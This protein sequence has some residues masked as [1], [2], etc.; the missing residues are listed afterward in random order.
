M[1]ENT[2]PHRPNGLGHNFSKISAMN[3]T[4]EM[5]EKVNT[6][7]NIMNMLSGANLMGPTSKDI[8]NQVAKPNLKAGEEREGEASEK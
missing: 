3:V 1:V 8:L 7:I 4:P 5:I 6:D 2:H